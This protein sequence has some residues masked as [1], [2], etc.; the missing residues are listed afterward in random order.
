[1]GEK[2][3]GFVAALVGIAATA[4]SALLLRGALLLGFPDGHRTGLDRLRAMTWP[5]SAFVFALVAV[6]ALVLFVQSLR[7]RSLGKVTASRLVAAWLLLNAL[8]LGVDAIA[9]ALR[10]PQAEM[11]RLT[12]DRIPLA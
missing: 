1:M 11:G 4:E 12:F 8:A 7:G 9:V 10:P 6:A 3:W 5:A 2:G